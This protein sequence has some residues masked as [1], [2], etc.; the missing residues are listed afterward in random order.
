MLAATLCRTEATAFPIGSEQVAS[1]RSSMHENFQPVRQ[2]RSSAVDVTKAIRSRSAQ[3]KPLLSPSWLG[4]GAVSVSNNS[5]LASL[6][7]DLLA[8]GTENFGLCVDGHWASML[9]TDTA[10]GCPKPQSSGLVFE[11]VAEADA[12]AEPRMHSRRRV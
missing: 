10:Q 8:S 7:T 1:A 12:G 11:D 3:P 9:N 5:G 6:Q 4:L 2:S